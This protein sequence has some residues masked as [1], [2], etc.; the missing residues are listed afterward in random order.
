MLRPSWA[1]TADRRAAQLAVAGLRIDAVAEALWLDAQPEIAR[2][3]LAPC[4]RQR[5]MVGPVSVVIPTC[6]RP[7][8][9]LDAWRS[10]LGQSRPACEIIVVDDGRRPLNRGLVDRLDRRITLLR[11]EGCRVSAAPETRARRSPAATFWPS[12]TTTTA[13]THRS[14]RRRWARSPARAP[15]WSRPAPSTS[16]RADAAGKGKTASQALDPGGFLRRNRGIK[17][18]NV[19]LRRAVFARIGASTSAC[20]RLTTS[21]SRS[22]SASRRR[23]MPGASIGR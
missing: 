7:D 21:T 16:P 11:T 23:A 12:S 8:P 13:G 19:V 10:V 1:Q 4:D 5:E 22:A 18:S 20:A 14:W 3:P 6:D 15:T 2:M 17:G 9:L